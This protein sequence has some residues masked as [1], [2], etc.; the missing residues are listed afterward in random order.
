MNLMSDSLDLS[1]LPEPLAAQ[2]RAVLLA[3]RQA[4]AEADRER[5][6]RSS[7]EAQAKVLAEQ[8]ARLEYLIKEIRRALYG[9]RSEKLHP[10]QL[11]LALEDLETAAAEAQEAVKP[12]AGRAAPQSK[13]KR[14][15]GH[16]P[17][18]LPRIALSVT[19][20]DR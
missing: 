4:R 7:A 14:N 20:V 12:T 11:S 18:A 13:A 1:A 19:P 17:K 9:R 5:Q 2:I 8:V 10:D 15:L 6:A 3:E 16:L